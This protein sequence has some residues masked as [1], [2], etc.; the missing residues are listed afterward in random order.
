MTTVEAD[1]AA[2]NVAFEASAEH[3]YKSTRPWTGTSYRLPRR[4]KLAVVLDHADGEVVVREANVG[5][6]GTGADAMAAIAD[7]RQA[8]REHLEVLEHQPAL[9][10]G[11]AEQLEYLRERSLH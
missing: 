8:V 3:T 1:T 10:P 6:F 4:P 7:F 9:A 11:L 5:I 2:P